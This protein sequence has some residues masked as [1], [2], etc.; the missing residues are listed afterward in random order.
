M[1]NVIDML[2][3]DHR[4]AEGLFEEFAETGDEQVAAMVCNDL[5]LHTEIE[6]R[7][8]Y[9]ALRQ[10]DGGEQLVEEALR[11]HNEAKQLIERIRGT[12][13]DELT[14][15][16]DE[17]EAAVEHHVSEEESEVFPKLETLGTAR[18]S[19]LASQAADIKATRAA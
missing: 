14:D 16:M 15:L 5:T 1:A 19:D 10:L 13:G 3:E 9:P 8:I 12:A 4:R 17:L 2:T 11:E 7:A 6:E 18:L